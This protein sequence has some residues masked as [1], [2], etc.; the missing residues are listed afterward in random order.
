MSVP[1]SEFTRRFGLLGD[2][3]LGD[4]TVE[5]I[6]NLNEIDP[7]VYRIGPSQVRDNMLFYYVFIMS[8]I[9]LAFTF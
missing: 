3:A 1:L 8:F 4:V 9:F 7:S 6:L 5:N 2:G